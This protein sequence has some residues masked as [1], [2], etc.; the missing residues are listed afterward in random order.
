MKVKINNITYDFDIADTQGK[1]QSDKGSFV[2]DYKIGPNACFLKKINND[3]ESFKFLASIKGKEVIGIP[4]LYDIVNNGDISILVHQFKKGVILDK[5]LTEPD[6]RKYIE[7]NLNQDRIINKLYA[8]LHQIHHHGYWHND[9]CTR[10]IQVTDNLDFIILDLDSAVHKSEMPNALNLKDSDKSLMGVFNNLLIEFHN[11]KCIGNGIDGFKYN[12]LQLASLAVY[13]KYLKFNPGVRHESKLAN[14]YDKLITFIRER[15]SRVENLIVK[16]VSEILTINDLLE[17]V[18]Y[19]DVPREKAEDRPIDKV[20][21]KPNGNGQKDIVIP[22]IKI[23]KFEAVPKIAA[24]NEPFS[25]SWDVE[26]VETV[27]I[28]GLGIKLPSKHTFKTNIQSAKSFTLIAGNVTKTIKVDVDKDSYPKPVFASVKINGK[29]VNGVLEL[30]KGTKVNIEWKVENA[31]VVKLNNMAYK[32]IS[33]HSFIFNNYI[34]LSLVADNESQIFKTSFAFPKIIEIREKP[35]P[36]LKVPVINKFEING[37]SVIS[38]D[39]YKIYQLDKGAQYKIAWAISDATSVK[40]ND[41]D[42]PTIGYLTGTLDGNEKIFKIEA[43]NTRGQESRSCSPLRVKLIAR[44]TQPPSVEPVKIIRFA[45]GLKSGYDIQA[46]RQNRYELTS[47]QN[48]KWDIFIELSE[49][50][51]SFWF[52]MDDTDFKKYDTFTNVAFPINQYLLKLPDSVWYN[53][54][55]SLRTF[56]LKIND[57]K[58]NTFEQQ[59]YLKLNLPS[60]DPEAAKPLVKEP[61]ILNFQ[62]YLNDTGDKIYISW[63]TENIKSMQ[64]FVGN[65]KVLTLTDQK[66]LMKD[67]FIKKFDLLSNDNI[68]KTSTLVSIKAIGE[69]GRNIQK[70]KSISFNYEMSE[71]KESTEKKSQWGIKFLLLILIL[72]GVELMLL[73]FTGG[74]GTPLRDLCFDCLFFLYNWNLVSYPILLILIIFLLNKIFKK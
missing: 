68:G 14:D 13:F 61:K 70:E 16:G 35:L 63:K 69:N 7:I 67:E 28:D 42:S 48:G 10:N 40:I 65:I 32:P 6:F 25:L 8:G 26:G 72:I 27:N 3:D 46:S 24:F 22:N 33:S 57:E 2:I 52:M 56:K 73:E 49:S 17:I 23:K 29:D 47:A 43:S 41:K 34:T 21:D 38:N 74:P 60:S 59:I 62:A 44:T 4:P 45:P 19:L 71:R 11:M 30:E 20:P 1:W 18:K 37:Q 31:T 12:M 5:K 53:R 66:Y 55:K 51:K 58:G 64:L 54:E 9:L 36:P 39:Y 15:H 50:V